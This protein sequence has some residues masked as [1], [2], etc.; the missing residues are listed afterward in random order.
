M[1]MM[2]KRSKNNGSLGVTILMI[3]LIKFIS[4]KIVIVEIMLIVLFLAG[5]YF[6]VTIPYI[7]DFISTALNVLTP[8]ALIAL[9]VYVI[10]SIL[11]H[12]FVKIILAIVLIVL[13]Y[14]YFKKRV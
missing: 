2:W 1:R 4:E 9:V 14:L 5:N 6:G 7:T 8:I 13:A 10:F 11:D 3:K 12:E